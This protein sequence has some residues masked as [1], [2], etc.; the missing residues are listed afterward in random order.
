MPTGERREAFS[1]PKGLS[2]HRLTC[3]LPPWA[4]ER[5]GEKGCLLLSTAPSCL[6]EKQYK[7]T[8][9]QPRVLICLVNCKHDWHQGQA[10]GAGLTNMSLLKYC[11]PL[12]DLKF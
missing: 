7:S 5:Q 1:L 6:T 2:F 12:L 11:S 10:A 4:K 9:H 8:K 3:I